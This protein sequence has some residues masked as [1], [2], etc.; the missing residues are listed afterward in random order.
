MV[1]PL[2]AV[3]EDKRRIAAYYTLAV[4]NICKAEIPIKQ[5]LPR[6][7]IP[8]TLLARLAVD[9]HYQGQR[10]GEKSLITALRHTVKLCDE[11]LP[12]YGLVLDVLD[13]DA[14]KF[15]QQFDCFYRFTDNPMRLFSPMSVLRKI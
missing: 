4:S 13:S 5:S 9:I 1:L 2:D 15:Y 10:L 11:G 7:P 8:V 6:Y 14:L 12:T 3:T